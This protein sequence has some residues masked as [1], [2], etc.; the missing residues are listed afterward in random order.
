M[1]WWWIGS[2]NNLWCEVDPYGLNP[3]D[4]HAY[5]WEHF[6]ETI[7]HSRRYFFLD[8]D[9]G[10]GSG[11]RS[12]ARVLRD[13]VEYA[14]DAGAVVTLPAGSKLYRARQ[15][16]RESRLTSARELGPPPVE[17]HGA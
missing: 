13:I 12:P 15:E 5:S 9:P 6:C 1:I 8:D 16:P 4:E 10:D 11:L 17:C 7:K 2:T 3:I 14:S